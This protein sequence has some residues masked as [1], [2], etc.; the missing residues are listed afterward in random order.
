MGPLF[1]DRILLLQFIGTDNSGPPEVDD[2]GW[3]II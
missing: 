2:S 1:R 3:R